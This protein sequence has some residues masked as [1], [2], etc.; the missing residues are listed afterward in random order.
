MD[1]N[2]V[3][4]VACLQDYYNN[5]ITEGDVDNVKCIDPSCGKEESAVKQLPRKRRRRDRTLN[6][7]ELLQIPISQEQVLRYVRLKR[8]NR[9]ESDKTTVYCPRQWCQGAARNKKHPKPVDE[10]SAL[11]DTEDDA[12][13]EQATISS[14]NTKKKKL[15]SDPI[16]MA[17]RLAVCEDCTFAF[18]IVCRKGWHGLATICDPRKQDELDAEELATQAYLKRYSTPCP[19]CSA[20]TQKTMGCNHMLCAKCK[21]HFCYLCSAY[22]LSENP[23]KHYSDVEGTCYRRLWEL[24]AGDGEVAGQNLPRNG[25][26]E[27]PIP[28]DAEIIVVDVEQLNLDLN[29]AED[30]VDVAQRNL[31]EVLG[32]EED[33]DDEEPAPAIRPRGQVVEIINYARGEQAHARR[34]HVPDR[35]PQV[36]PPVPDAPLPRAARRRRRRQGNIHPPAGAPAWAPDAILV[37]EAVDLVPRVNRLG[38]RMRNL[39]PRIANARAGINDHAAVEGLRD[40]VRRFNHAVALINDVAVRIDR[41]LAIPRIH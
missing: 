34:I 15:K 24:E 27:Q 3:F 40:A 18:C 2:H 1:C 37:D 13:S 4:C 9:L 38:A 8:K 5:C 23:Y 25:G 16:P 28:V 6:S 20:P 19:T 39:A 11:T 41:V 12:E 14:Q 21:T 36:P 30:E 31:N 32:E 26:G 29:D 10:L 17:E 7:S 22:L 33:T 35:A